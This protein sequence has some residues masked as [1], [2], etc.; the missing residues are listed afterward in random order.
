MESGQREGCILTPSQGA[1]TLRAT[2]MEITENVHSLLCTKSLDGQTD[3]NGLLGTP[4]IAFPIVSSMSKNC[5]IQC[6]V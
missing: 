6:V 4:D 3:S 2:E 5:H 1:L